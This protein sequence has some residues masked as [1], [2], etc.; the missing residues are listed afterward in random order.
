MSA[1]LRRAH[2]RRHVVTVYELQVI[3]DLN[4]MYSFLIL[5]EVVSAETLCLN[6][7]WKHYSDF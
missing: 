7:R 6:S 4:V 2:R 5:L 1:L 3:L